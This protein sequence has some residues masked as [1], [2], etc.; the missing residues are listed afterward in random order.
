MKPQTKVRT[1]K[2]NP[3]TEAKNFARGGT[4]LSCETPVEENE[5]TCE[6]GECHE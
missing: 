3:E 6:E 5:R 1:K 4:D 2:D